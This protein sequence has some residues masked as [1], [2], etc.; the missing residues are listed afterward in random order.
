MATDLNSLSTQYPKSF[1]KLAISIDK[2]ETLSDNKL[3]NADE[4][5][6]NEQIRYVQLKKKVSS[7][8]KKFQI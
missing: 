8:F 2:F 3:L 1:K 4:S 5:K 7:E 6:L